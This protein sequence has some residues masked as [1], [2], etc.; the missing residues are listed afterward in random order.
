MCSSGLSDAF[1]EKMSRALVES[2]K[3]IKISEKLVEV[4]LHCPKSTSEF[5]TSSVSKLSDAVMDLTT[6]NQNLNNIYKFRRMPDKS[7][8]TLAGAEDQY[9]ACSVA[10]KV[11]KE[12]HQVLKSLQRG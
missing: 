12:M 10:H 7:T 3:M 1:K 8:A 2:D 4:C 11:C 5:W 9:Q 6:A